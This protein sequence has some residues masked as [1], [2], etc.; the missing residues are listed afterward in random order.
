ML[1]RGPD[2]DALK[3]DG[4]RRYELVSPKILH[5]RFAFLL[6]GTLTVA[7]KPQIHLADAQA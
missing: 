7:S 2:A 4:R 1:V 5:M 6:N 3:G